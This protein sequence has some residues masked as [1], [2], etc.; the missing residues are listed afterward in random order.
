[1]PQFINE[2]SWAMYSLGPHEVKMDVRNKLGLDQDFCCGAR[3][4]MCLASFS[5]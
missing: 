2:I 1:M 4:L 5:Y 3:V